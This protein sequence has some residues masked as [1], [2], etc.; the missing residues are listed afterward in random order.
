MSLSAWTIERALPKGMWL[1]GRV[2]IPSTMMSAL[3][4]AEI[5]AGLRP[6]RSLGTSEDDEEE[7][8]EAPVEISLARMSA[9]ARSSLSPSRGPESYLGWCV[10]QGRVR[11]RGNG[12]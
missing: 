7:E 10:D 9:M 3:G 6:L 1:V 11:R 12:G 4:V 5:W 2:M 8:E